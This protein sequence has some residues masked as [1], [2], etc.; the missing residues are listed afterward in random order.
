MGRSV[1]TGSVALFAFLDDLK[2]NNDRRWFAANRG[3]YEQVR[4]WWLEQLQALIN[5]LAADDP[6]L[7][8]LEARDCCY[9]IYR[10]TRFSHDKTPY[11]TYVSALISP[12]GRHFD[13]ACHYIHVGADECGLYSGLWAP[14]PR[15]L[16]K[17]RKAIIDNVDEFRSIVET[18]EIEKQFPG[19]YGNKLKTAPKGYDRN[20]PDIDLLRLTEY[21]RLHPLGRQFF[22]RD[23]WQTEA[24][25]LLR[26]LKPMNDFL[27][28]SITE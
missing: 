16:K 27:N 17:V 20:H 21:G 1:D 9:R 6:S 5:D 10:D 12:R 28:Y 7:R 24:A 23:D 18:P 4:A 13:G 22:G 3:R 19:W 8:H 15:V 2:A 11:K 14:E 26:L 25:R